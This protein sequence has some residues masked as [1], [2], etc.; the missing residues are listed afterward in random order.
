MS[1]GELRRERLTSQSDLLQLLQEAAVA[2][3][4]DEPVVWIR[5]EKMHQTCE[6][7]ERDGTGGCGTLWLL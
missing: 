6:K 1:K 5:A 3:D 4:G 2:E 7:E